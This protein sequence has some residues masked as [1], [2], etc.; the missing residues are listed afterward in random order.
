CLDSYAMR[1]IYGRQSREIHVRCNVLFPRCLVGV[2]T[3]G[4]LTISHDG[5][6]MTSCQELL[7]G[8]AVVDDR[9]E[10][11]LHSGSYLLH[12]FERAQACFNALSG[13]GLYAVTVEVFQFYR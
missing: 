8:I 4:V 10:P 9:Y 2:C 7:A 12:V 1:S 3:R 5:A 6:A 11:M 13:F